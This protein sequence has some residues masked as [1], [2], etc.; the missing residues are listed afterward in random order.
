MRD[1]LLVLVPTNFK[2]QNLTSKRVGFISRS[3][4]WWPLR[5]KLSHRGPYISTLETLVRT[6][7]KGAGSQ[8]AGLRYEYGS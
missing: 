3:L 5:V 1:W 7:P 2:S 4:G 8:K 6:K